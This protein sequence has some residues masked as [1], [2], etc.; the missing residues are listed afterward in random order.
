MSKKKYYVVRNG[1]TPGI[2]LSWD[3]CKAQVE[4]YSGAQYKGFTNINEAEAYLQTRNTSEMRIMQPN[5]KDEATKSVNKALS[6]AFVDGS[7]NETLGIYGYGGF[8]HIADKDGY[9][10]DEEI[11]GCGK[12][13][14]M[15]QMHNVAGEILGS[16]AAV[17]AAIK[18][19]LE[20][21]TIFYDYNGIEMWATGAWKRNK[22]GTQNYYE[23]MQ[24]AKKKIKINFVKVKGHAGIEGNERA[25]KLAKEAV[26]LR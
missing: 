7:Y 5:S 6:Y 11:K 3:D 4:G 2:Y 10:F 15:A 24:K 1:R 16:M 21:I 14:E 18:Y 17:T 20:E 25:D 12:D 23:F 13:P 19:E 9:D 26:G 22:L 8:I